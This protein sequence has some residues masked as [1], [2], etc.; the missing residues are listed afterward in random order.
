M[1]TVGELL[2]E[3]KNNFIKYMISVLNNED[4]KDEITTIEIQTFR[5]NIG[6]LQKISSEI[7]ILFIAKELQ[8]QKDK[9]NEYINHFLQMNGI[10]SES[11][12][13][14]D[15][16]LKDHP[17]IFTDIKNKVVQY[18]QLFIDIYEYSFQE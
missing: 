2:Q 3:K 13:L 18:L 5:E 7:F 1:S 12:L 9:L 17:Q 4:V 8:P 6:K 10:C 16:N 11:F 15:E 14:D